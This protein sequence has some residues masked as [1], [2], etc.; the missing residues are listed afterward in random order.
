MRSYWPHVTDPVNTV[1]ATLNNG[2]KYVASNTLNDA[3][4]AWGDTTMLRGN[5]IEQVRKL[6]ETPGG[7][8]QVHGS[9]RLARNLHDAGL[10]DVYRLVQFPVLVG[11]GK[12]LFAHGVAPA[13]YQIAESRALHGGKGAT[14]LTLHQTTFG[15]AAVGEFEVR[16]G[17]EAVAS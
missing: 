10:V 5:V 16:D 6:K 4:T 3:D 7:D 15:I 2:K 11:S 8:L 13:T 12:R 9:W 1:A 14:L 17:K